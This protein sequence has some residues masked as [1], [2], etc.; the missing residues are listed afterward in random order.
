MVEGEKVT[1]ACFDSAERG[2][3]QET[4]DSVSIVLPERP[5]AD[6]AELSEQVDVA[7][8]RSILWRMNRVRR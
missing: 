7:G 8:G 1:G 2:P 5:K 3:A 6:E 4:R